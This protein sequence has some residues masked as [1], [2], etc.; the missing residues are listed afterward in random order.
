VL[1]PIAAHF[2]TWSP[3]A[4]SGTLTGMR[5]SIVVP[6]CNEELRIGQMLDA[7]L[8]Y[9]TAKC[10]RDVEILVVVNGT[11]DRTEEVVSRYAA[12]YPIL[13]CVVDP[14]RIGKGGALM[15]G[16]AEAHGELVGF[17]DAD[18]S[19]PP[20]A[21]QDLVAH[22]GDS[23][24]I[25]ASRWRRGAKVSPKQPLP[26]LIASRAFN[27]V[28][29]VFFGLRLT[30]TQCGAKLMRREAL[31]A[32]LPHLGTTRWA[33]DVDL[34][35][36]LR[37]AG[38]RVTEVATTWCDVAGSKVRVGRVSLEMFLAL[39]RLRLVYSPFRWMVSVY[40]RIGFKVGAPRP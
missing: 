10:S 35:F 16:F 27:L 34:L 28:T 29:R 33:F 1:P 25:I 18:G 9:L 39:V 4:D 7:Y 13:R 12:R 2:S 38:Y 40:N 19:T 22:I 20:D 31:Q 37:R 5:L 23:G 6:A 30:D 24:A 21:F 17:V 8:P 11:T 3:V 14:A 36:Q 15:R 26:R 32:V